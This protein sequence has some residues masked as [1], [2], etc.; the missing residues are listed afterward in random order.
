[1]P[2]ASK[3]FFTKAILL[4]YLGNWKRRLCA[5]LRWK[6][7]PTGVTR[8]RCVRCALRELAKHQT[9]SSR[10][11]TTWEP[12]RPHSPSQRRSARQLEGLDGLQKLGLKATSGPD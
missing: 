2:N 11:P 8:K 1:M 12:N 6:K 3:T 7:R 10:Q 9:T 5:Y 4:R